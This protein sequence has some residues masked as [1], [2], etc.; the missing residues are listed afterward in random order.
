M[1][2]VRDHFHFFHCVVHTAF[3]TIPGEAAVRPVGRDST[4]QCMSGGGKSGKSA[5]CILAEGFEEMEAVT[6]IDLLRRAGVEVT[7]ASLTTDIIV[8]GRNGISVFANMDLDSALKLRESYDAVIVPGG[9]PAVPSVGTLKSDARVLSLL[10]EQMNA[11][12]VV[13]AICAAPSVLAEAGVLAGKKYTAHFSVA[14]AVPDFDKTSA[15]VVD[16]NLV[17]SQGAG[18]GTQFGLALIEQL[19][20]KQTAEEVAASICWK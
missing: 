13:S 20:D 17:T 14:D 2:F 18:T 7:I 12:R 4:V 3:V 8:K 11:G 15:V 9:P 5:L 10:N 16:G 19:V 6:P 1:I